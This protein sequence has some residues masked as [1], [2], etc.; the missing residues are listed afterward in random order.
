M[1]ACRAK[2]FVLITGV[3]QMAEISLTCDS[4]GDNMRIEKN[5]RDLKQL[6]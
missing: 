4:C 6:S 1:A 2:A 5:C 3:I